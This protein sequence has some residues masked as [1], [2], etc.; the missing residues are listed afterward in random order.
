M[1]G[2][3]GVIPNSP[4]R[5]L[6]RHIN[7]PNGTVYRRIQLSI[8]PIDCPTDRGVYLY[9]RGYES[10]FLIVTVEESFDEG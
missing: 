1:R 9:L 8:L 7:K 3:V 4:L 10:H 2:G 6:A 5:P